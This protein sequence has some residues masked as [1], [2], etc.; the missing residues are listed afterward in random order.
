MKQ[1][2]GM[3]LLS[4]AAV[5]SV[6]GQ[7]NDNSNRNT[8]CTLTLAQAPEIRGFHL[9][10][11]MEQV[12]ARFPGLLIEPANEFGSTKIELVFLDGTSPTLNPKDVTNA[13]YDSKVYINREKFSG[14]DGVFTIYLRFFD[15]RI[16][17]IR[18][19]YDGSTKWNTTDEF[20]ARISESLGLPKSW[21]NESDRLSSGGLFSP[22]A[23]VS[24]RGERTLECEGFKAS[25]KF[26][27]SLI[28]EEQ[29]VLILEDTVSNQGAEK[30]RKEKEEKER[31]EEEERRKI[32]KP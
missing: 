1:I 8:K 21:Q 23:S 13:R 28:M 25:A 29:P 20:V 3:A 14:F 2:L 12:L 22:R 27:Y 10:M 7:S 16:S 31:R 11:S 32:F 30:R 9:G 26:D 24:P 18:I 19:M 15:S 6:S 17:L 5:I 4:L